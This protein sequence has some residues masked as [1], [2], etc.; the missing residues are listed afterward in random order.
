MKKVKGIQFTILHRWCQMNSTNLILHY[1][2]Q[3]AKSPTYIKQ[4]SRCLSLYVSHDKLTTHIILNTYSFQN[5][6]HHAKYF[7]VLSM[8]AWRKVLKIPISG[9]VDQLHNIYE[10]LDLNSWTT[11]R[12]RLGRPL[13]N[14]IFRIL[15][16]FF[17]D[18]VLT[19][20]SWLVTK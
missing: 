17:W 4:M 1:I 11:N 5:P 7:I 15:T 13:T 6:I 18:R 3:G 9:T 14:C 10:A 12:K 16:R 20:T 2:R 19:S 8:C